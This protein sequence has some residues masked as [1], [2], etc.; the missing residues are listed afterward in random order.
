MALRPLRRPRDAR[1]RAGVIDRQ[2]VRRRRTIQLFDRARCAA[3]CNFRHHLHHDVERLRQGCRAAIRAVTL[4][5]RRSVNSR[6][7]RCGRQPGN[8]THRS[9]RSRRD[10]R[11]TGNRSR[12]R[13]R[14]ESGRL[15]VRRHARRY[16]RVDAS[17]DRRRQANVSECRIDFRVYLRGGKVIERGDTCRRRKA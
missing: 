15:R 2:R 1:R 9:D 12:E 5:H 6:R 17:R 13:R 14:K 16:R 11:R 8:A 7:Y 10:I 4:R 3:E